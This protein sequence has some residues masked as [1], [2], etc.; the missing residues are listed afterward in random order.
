M[1]SPMVDSCYV[2][3]N[4]LVSLWHLGGRVY[5]IRMSFPSRMAGFSQ[6]YSLWNITSLVSHPL[7]GL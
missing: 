1:T 5:M 4:S 2:A 3:E 7:I 6:P